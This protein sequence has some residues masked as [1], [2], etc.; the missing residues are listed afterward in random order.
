[1]PSSARKSRKIT[2]GWMHY[3]SKEKRFVT[4]RLNNGGG[5]RRIDVPFDSTKQDLIAEGKK[6]FFPGGQSTYGKE[7]EML[8]NLANFRAET[9]EENIQTDE[10]TA[11]FTIQ[12]YIEKH[13]LTLVRLYLT[14]KP[15]APDEDDYDLMQSV[16]ERSVP[17]KPKAK[18]KDKGKAWRLNHVNLPV[19]A[20]AQDL[21][22]LPDSSDSF[23]QLESDDMAWLDYSLLG[24]SE[25]RQQLMTEQQEELQQS[26]EVDR[27]KEEARNELARK[28]ETEADRLETVRSFRAARVPPEPKEGTSRVRIAVHHLL[29]G[30]LVR[31]FASEDR[32]LSVYD[33]IGS[34]AKQPENFHLCISPEDVVLPSDPVS[35][36]TLFMQ[37]TDEPVFLLE[38]YDVTFKGYG[39]EHKKEDPLKDMER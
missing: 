2:L 36:C 18:K 13:K 28:Q 37:V 3:S 39:Y 26:I 38:D 22:F 8:F 14:S 7:E 9:V 24:T 21:C 27:R 6:L 30:R 35:S 1:M 31:Y 12:R 25:E 23:P 4:V 10:T 5:T 16:F 20:D 11:D 33:W 32:M 15:D 17:A 34:R 29:E 19:D